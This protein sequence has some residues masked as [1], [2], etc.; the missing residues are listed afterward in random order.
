MSAS[1]LNL[2]IGGRIYTLAV[3]EDQQQRLKYVAT[4]VDEVFNKLRTN[5]PDVERDRL[6]V[7][8]LLQIT[9]ELVSLKQEWDTER[10]SISKLHASIA[11]KLEA[12]L[13]PTQ[14]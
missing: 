9:D 10:T 14:A 6:F 4:Q 13:P 5:S 2:S 11:D 8:A 7:L 3:P 12:L 1:P